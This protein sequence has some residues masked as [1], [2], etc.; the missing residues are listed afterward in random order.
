MHQKSEIYNQLKQ[1]VGL[2]DIITL[3]CKKV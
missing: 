2:M 1:M 3:W